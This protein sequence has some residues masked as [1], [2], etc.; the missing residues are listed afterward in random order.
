M[1]SGEKGASITIFDFLPHPQWE[2]LDKYKKAVMLHLP[3]PGR[4]PDDDNI[5]ELIS[6]HDKYPDITI[7]IAHFGRSFCPSYLEEGLNKLGDFDGFYFDTAAVINPD[8]YDIAF[9]SI[10]S[11]RILYG[12]DL[13]ITTWHG[14]RKWTNREYVNLCRK[15]YSWKK[16][17]ETQEKESQYTL[18]IYEE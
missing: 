6:A 1:V 13:P 3:R 8:V 14:K 12:S 2:I 16:E 11:T 10:K 17:R 18:F 5:R 15:E 9:N 4:L 7:I